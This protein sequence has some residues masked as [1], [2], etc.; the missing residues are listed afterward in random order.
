MNKLYDV[1][2]Q[3]KDQDYIELCNICTRI[4]PPTPPVQFIH[5]LSGYGICTTLHMTKDRIIETINDLGFL[6]DD[7][8][9]IFD[10]DDVPLETDDERI[11]VIE[12]K[13]QKFFIGQCTVLEHVES[14]VSF[15]ALNSSSCAQNYYSPTI[16]EQLNILWDS[17]KDETD[18]PIMGHELGWH[19]VVYN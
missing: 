7:G 13:P 6:Y 10:D 2:Q 1:S 19:H 8:V 18:S 9:M 17:L 3:M 11:C 12:I 5:S 4:K 15:P 14:M 16:K